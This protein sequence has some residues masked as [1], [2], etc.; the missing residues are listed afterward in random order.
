M[1]TASLFILS[2]YMTIGTINIDGRDVKVQ[3]WWPTSVHHSLE[4]CEKEAGDKHKKIK[5]KCD[6]I[7]FQFTKTGG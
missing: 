2:I 5:F 6:K 7:D 1:T 4:E 3:S